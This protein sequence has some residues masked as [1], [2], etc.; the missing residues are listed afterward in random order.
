[1]TLTVKELIKQ[2]KTYPEDYLVFAREF[3]GAYAEIYFLN[4][5]DV[6]KKIH[7]NLE[8]PIPTNIQKLS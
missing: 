5:D 1:M 2:L 7:I 4:Y 3:S 6:D 8:K